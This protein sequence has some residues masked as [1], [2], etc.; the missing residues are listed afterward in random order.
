MEIISHRGLW[1]DNIIKNSVTA[2]EESFFNGFGTETDIR[3]Y[4]G[5]LVIS[6]DIAGDDSIDFEEFLELYNFSSKK[7]LAL[8]IKSDG[9]ANLLKEK[10][11]K[12]S[13]ENYF[14]FDMSIP[15]TLQYKLNDIKF[16]IRQSEFEKDLPFYHD[17]AGIWLDSFDSIWYD[18][19]IIAKHIKN[20]KKV[21][22]V[23]SEL[24]KRDKELLWK[25]LINNDF[26]KTENLI[27]C[28]DFAIEAN[29]YFNL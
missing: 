12:N 9:L 15:D 29:K 19:E 7:T 27:L 26:Y 11:E 8:N 2:F 14:V 28:T 1:S 10:L 6:H 22:I 25:L 18:Q 3:D 5:K 4:N 20:G 21:C 17:C 13:I 24:H 16:Y 23:S